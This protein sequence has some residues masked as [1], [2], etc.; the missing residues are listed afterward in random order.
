M[1][2][3]DSTQGLSAAAIAHDALEKVQMEATGRKLRQTN[4]KTTKL[5]GGLNE[6]LLN[7]ADLKRSAKYCESISQLQSRAQLPRFVIGV[8]GGTGTGKSSLINAVLDEERIVPTNCMR[9]CTAVVTEILWNSSED[10]EKKYRAEIEFLTQA[11]WTQELM[12]LH[13]DM[14]DSDGKISRDARDQNTDAGTAYAILRSVYPD[15]TDEQLE[16]THPTALASQTTVRQVLGK[17]VLIEEQACEVFYDKIQAYVDSEEN[18]DSQTT[19]NSQVPKMAHWPLVKVVRIFLKSKILSTGV[20]LVDLPGSQDTNIAR[21]AVAAKYAK[22]CTRLWIVA[23]ITRAVNDKTAKNLMGEHFKKQLKYDGT[24]ANITFIYTKADDIAL[25]EASET[26]GIKDTISDMYRRWKKF[27]PEIEGM[28]K[29]ARKLEI[30]KSSLHAE[31][32]VAAND[33]DT[34][35]GIYNHAASGERAFAPFQSPQKRRRPADHDSSDE[36]ESSDDSADELAQDDHREPVTVEIASARLQELK[37]KKKNLKDGKKEVGRELSR[38]RASIKQLTTERSEMNTQMYK[39]CIQG[40][41][42]F[43]R[44][45]IQKDFASGLK[46]LDDELLATQA[47]NEERPHDAGNVSDADYEKIGRELPVFCISSRGYQQLRGRMKKDRRVPGFVSSE[48]TEVPGLQSHTLDFAA[49]IQDDYFKS[50][51]NEVCR[52]LR[53]MDVFLAGDEVLLKMSNAEREDECKHL[54]KSLAK[55][56]S[57]LEESVVTCMEDCEKT[58]AK[59]L[60]R[61]PK[62]AKKASAEA[63]AMA[64]SWGAARESGGLRFPTYRATC[65]RRGTFKGAAGPRDFNEDLLKPMKDII[66]G[67]WDQ[68]FNKRFP[69]LLDHLASTF[70]RLIGAFHDRMQGRRFLMENTDLV[71]DILTKHIA[72]LKQALIDM[73]KQ[74]KKLAREAQRGA[75]RAFH[76][77]IEGSLRD[78]YNQCA[79]V[80]GA[81]AFIALR[82]TME[83]QIEEKRKMV[84]L[85]AARD[86]DEAVHRLLED[87]EDM[88]RQSLKSVIS[89][90]EEDYIG[91]IGKVA[92]EADN[93][94]RKMLKPVVED[95]YQ[96]LLVALSE[97]EEDHLVDEVADDREVEDDEEGSLY[98]ESG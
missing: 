90:M 6:T 45:E 68:T 92:T 87:L 73:A 76:P 53:G 23:P 37:D 77:A 38:L 42:K 71:H 14:I 86:T 65:R 61:L 40:R 5:L 66:A 32:Q 59:V 30:K 13:R 3:D 72:A 12:Q 21:A 95:F 11:E 47:Q 57:A 18:I 85:D 9:A 41:N 70:A 20:V 67:Y 43:S 1:D 51:L 48:D 33:V 60:T 35:Q 10:V 69:E 81:G 2:G 78:T 19:G 64:K 88:I 58:A 39:M 96:K 49:A 52:L 55:L 83:T 82:E 97:P 93:R 28:R 26:L 25:D 89:T 31:Y 4:L 27:K 56:R 22:E 8:L 74:H 75:N 46:E 44:Q 17:T 54:E 91:L 80:R 7:M 79:Q 16:Q 62:A 84:F 63:L 29:D 36:G 24:Y 15:V 50:H 98:H 94:D 34:W